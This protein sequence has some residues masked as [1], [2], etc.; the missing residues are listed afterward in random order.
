MC[1]LNLNL[2][3][4]AGEII[5]VPLLYILIT[6]LKAAGELLSRQLLLE[7][8]AADLC[9]EGDPAQKDKL[10]SGVEACMW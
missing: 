6:D 10:V 8:L 1:P 4:D 7:E 3:A 9:F 2:R 5:P